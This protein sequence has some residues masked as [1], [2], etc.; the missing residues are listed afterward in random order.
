VKDAPNEGSYQG[1]KSVSAVLEQVLHYYH[2]VYSTAV[3]HSLLQFGIFSH[4]G[5]LYQEKSGKPG[6]TFSFSPADGDQVSSL[7]SSC[8]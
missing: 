7:C 1:I 3:G 2:L 8:Y 5:M 6:E 4:F